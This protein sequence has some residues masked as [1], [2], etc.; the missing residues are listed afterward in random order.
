[1]AEF[2]NSSNGGP[3][4]LARGVSLFTNSPRVVSHLQVGSGHNISLHKVARAYHLRALAFFD[5]VLSTDGT[6]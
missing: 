2:E 4:V 1:M 3:A 5:E 6:R